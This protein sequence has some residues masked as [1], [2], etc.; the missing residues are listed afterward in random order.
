M[1]EDVPYRASP[2]REIEEDLKEASA[3]K[4]QIHRV[5]LEGGDAFSLSGDR[6]IHIA[7]LIHDYLSRVSTIAMYANIKNIQ[8]KTDREL[9]ELHSLGVDELNIGL[10]SGDDEA[11]LYMNKG[12]TAKEA[13]RELGRLKAAGIRYGLNVI[14]GASGREG[15]PRSAEKTAEL[16]NETE[17]YLLFTGT[18]HADPGCKL[19]DDM[20]AGKFKECTVRGYIEEGRKFLRQLSLSD[21]R[22]FGLHPSNIVPMQGILPKEKE[23]LIHTLDAAEKELSNEILDSIPRRAGEGAVMLERLTIKRM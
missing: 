4:E 20:K 12:Y 7:N 14:F 18:I 5:F 1:Y 15:S 13:R 6:L 3:Y 19:Y 2:I 8:T 17:P 23:T 9:K 10:E 22:Y 16:I 11:L 21:C